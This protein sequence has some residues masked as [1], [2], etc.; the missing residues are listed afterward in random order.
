MSTP[1]VMRKVKVWRVQVGTENHNPVF[2]GDWFLG[3]DWKKESWPRD[4]VVEVREIFF[5]FI[6]RTCIISKG[7]IKVHSRQL[8]TMK[9]RRGAQV[10]Y[11][12]NGTPYDGHHV[13]HEE[14]HDDESHEANPL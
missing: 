8:W 11:A 5:S 4:T 2:K 10:L 12:N 3:E 6:W 1:Q 9:S 13:Y 7:R 14:A